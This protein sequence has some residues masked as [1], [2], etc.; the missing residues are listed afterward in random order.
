[1]HEDVVVVLVVGVEDEVVARSRRLV[2]HGLDKSAAWRHHRGALAGGEIL[3][4]VSVAVALGAEAGALAAPVE[5][6]GDR[7][8]VVGELDIGR[9]AGG[10]SAGRD[11]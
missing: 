6:A 1:M 7:E 4:L 11:R 2:L 5:H 9:A 8:G 3:S 10:G